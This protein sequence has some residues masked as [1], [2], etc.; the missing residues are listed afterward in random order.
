MPSPRTTSRCRPKQEWTRLLGTL[1]LGLL[2]WCPGAL[3]NTVSATL[4]PMPEVLRPQVEFWK[5]VFAGLE[6]TGGLLH[7]MEDL[8]IVYHIWYNDLPG[9]QPLR[10]MAIDEARD[11][12]RTILATLAEGKRT[13]L[14]SDEQRVWDM[15]RGKQYP[16][17]FRA[18]MS[19]M[20]FQGG[21]RGRFA[22]GLVRSWSYL[23]EMEQ[24]FA[25]EGVPIEITRLPHVESSFE[26]RALSK[27]GAAGVWQIMP[28]TG[29]RFLR[30]DGAVDERLHISTATRAAARLLR[31]NYEKLGTWP[32][33]IT[34]Y[35][36]GANGMKQAVATMGTTDF[37]VIVQRYRG[38]LFG[39]ASRNFYA[40]FLAALE[41][42]THHQQY[43][44]DVLQANPAQPLALAAASGSTPQ[45][46]LA[47]VEPAQPMT[48]E[49]HGHAPLALAALAEGQVRST[50]PTPPVADL[51]VVPAREQ[52]N[53]A[54]DP[55]I[56][57]STPPIV[58]TAL[59][60]PPAPDQLP[61]SLTPE[62][63]PVAPAPRLVTPPADRTAPKLAPSA[64]RYVAPAPTEVTPA[65]P[66]VA[67]TPRPAPV[68]PRVLSQP[69]PVVV[70][71]PVV[72][73]TPRRLPVEPRAQ[74][75]APAVVAAA[76]VPAPA[77]VR[78]DYKAYKVRP[79]ETL[80]GLA[81]RHGVTV[82]EVATANQLSPRT[83]V[84]AGQT[85]LL[86]A[87]PPPA[88]TPTPA[89]PALAVAQAE[90][91][92]AKAPIV[93]VESP[94]RST[95]V[96][97]V[98]RAMWS[99]VVPAPGPAKPPVT[100]TTQRRP[101]E[102]RGPQDPRSQED[103]FL[104]RNRVA[105]VTARKLKAGE[106]LAS[107]ARATPGVPLW[108]MQRY[109]AHLDLNTPRPGAEVRIPKL[110]AKS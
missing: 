17:T 39:F 8:S 15:F 9:T 7:D 13:D 58:S 62:P 12:Y 55:V 16:D 96:L 68:E 80:T 73:A 77:P 2:V 81:Q 11:Q 24:I 95:Q 106:T 93:P 20:R 31:E 99:E 41:V 109:N 64:P 110:S 3:A 60:V 4:F 23:P 97:P 70:P 28:A 38:P 102:A 36:H 87:L 50:L 74:P 37:G 84:Q 92:A 83:N 45:A 107:V 66:V 47:F 10:Q 51:P 56:D 89:P 98:Q 78:P 6:T 57:E 18:A 103:E 49:A 43:F 48:L 26:N 79:G 35:N 67:A 30:V 1:L 59:P 32:L 40:E 101:P 54:E 21:M 42:S 29:R 94:F 61:M 44:G 22:Q 91:P 105:E 34:A 53:L 46:F 86:P 71:P 76:P 25:S 5:R 85:L 75:P 82:A 52:P 88:R 100:P 108:L 19:N 63:T 72:A 33:A 14:S 65:P 90:K 69:A 27:V 104:R